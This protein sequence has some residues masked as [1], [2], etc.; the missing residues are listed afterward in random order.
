MSFGPFS[1]LILLFIFK[2]P[3]SFLS[4]FSG[5]ACLVSL[6]LFPFLL[7]PFY[8]SCPVSVSMFMNWLQRNVS[9]SGYWSVFSSFLYS[10]QVD[11]KRKTGTKSFVCLTCF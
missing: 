7:A 5:S 9:W 1:S 8:T 4:F 3:V 11:W 2:C 10:E 6:F